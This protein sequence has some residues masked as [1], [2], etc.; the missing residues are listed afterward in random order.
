MVE[1]K[2]DE[3]IL[4]DATEGTKQTFEILTIPAKR[5]KELIAFWKE[6]NSGIHYP[7][8]ID[9]GKSHSGS[10]SNGGRGGRRGRRR[11]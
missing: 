1:G 6:N 9:I 8:S 2:K 10:S 11:R 4:G 5:D 3:P 7:S